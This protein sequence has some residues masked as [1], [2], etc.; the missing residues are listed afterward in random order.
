MSDRRV[1]SFLRPAAPPPPSPLTGLKEGDRC[2][3]PHCG[4]LLMGRVVVTVDGSCD[5]LICSS[6][7]RA[8]LLRVHEPYVPMGREP[9][10]RVASLLVPEPQ[11]DAGRGNDDSMGIALPESLLDGLAPRREYY[12]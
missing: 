11:D 5:E 4:G 8:V 2:P 1:S 12:D 10:P 9:D 6:C 7:A 3:R